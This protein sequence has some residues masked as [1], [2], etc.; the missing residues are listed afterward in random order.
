MPSSPEADDSASRPA[1][2]GPT[3]P[4]YLEVLARRF[5]K[6]FGGRPDYVRPV[7]STEQVIVAVEEALR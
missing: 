5:N 4:R 3:D 7:S 1:K 2:L 6:R